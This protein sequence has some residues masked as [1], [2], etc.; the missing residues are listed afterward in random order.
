MQP[1]RDAGAS[2]NPLVPSSILRSEEGHLTGPDQVA[3]EVTHVL[4]SEP[5]SLDSNLLFSP[6]D[7]AGPSGLLRSSHL[8]L[9]L[10]WP[11]LGSAPAPLAAPL[12]SDLGPPPSA[13]PASI[14]GLPPTPPSHFGGPACSTPS[15]S[16]GPV[17]SCSP[18]T[19]DLALVVPRATRPSLGK[20]TALHR[21]TR[22]ASKYLGNRMPSLQRAQVLRC[23]NS[24]PLVVTPRK[25]SLLPGAP[26]AAACP[27]SASASSPLSSLSPSA[28]R[29]NTS[30]Q[31]SA[32]DL[33]LPLTAVEVSRIK[34]SCG[35]LDIPVGSL[36]PSSS[37]CWTLACPA[38]NTCEGV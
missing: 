2:L 27:G 25:T 14:L 15:I 38:Q 22:L 7:A 3:G 28:S 37:N 1:V 5:P 17:L 19:G 11:P 20:R 12:P 35:I 34:L 21:S 33:S 24:S 23:K 10:A 26:S 18:P 30:G 16:L 31:P 9:D 13:Q 8:S 29:V 4:Q 36:R 32:R 6:L